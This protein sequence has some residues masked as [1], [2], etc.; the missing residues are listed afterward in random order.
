MATQSGGKTGPGPQ[1]EV[2]AMFFCCGV[3]GGVIATVYGIAAAGSS[4]VP[5]VDASDAA[6]LIA[7]F[8]GAALGGG[9]SWLLARQT[10]RE[11]AEKEERQR[12]EIDTSTAAAACLKLLVITNA[13]FTL[14]QHVRRERQSHPQ[15][16][17]LHEAV[18]PIT[19]LTEHHSPFFVSDFLALFR[20][21]RG[22]LANRALLLEP[23]YRATLSTIK[24]Y[25]DEH[26]EFQRMIEPVRGVEV[27]PD[28]AMRL[29]GSRE[30]MAAIQ[31]K[32]EVLE[33]LITSIVSFIEEDL[34]EAQLLCA[35]WDTVL[36]GLFGKHFLNVPSEKAAAP[37]G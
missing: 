6:T 35:E 8:G 7:G 37:S 30:E 16:R 4:K 10:A 17:R 18:R 21:E 32:M 36:Y 26:L 5:L 24:T 33:N 29:Q 22:D 23:R 19:G 3:L 12:L 14:N 13:L 1:P 15:A 9:V 27:G 2:N 28:G 31:I 11:T 34:A 25:N 20:A